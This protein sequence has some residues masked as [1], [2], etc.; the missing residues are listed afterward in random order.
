MMK[1]SI[2]ALLSVLICLSTITY[3][4]AKSTTSNSSLASAIKLYKS[5][6]YSQTYEVL[7]KIVEKDPSNAVACY[8]L[9][10][11]SAQIGRKGESI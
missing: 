5:G 10:M 4:E 6:N 1:K 9:A 11:T 3:T 2:I 8:Y 7:H